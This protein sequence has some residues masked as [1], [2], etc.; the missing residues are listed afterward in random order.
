ME[1]KENQV[2]KVLYTNWRGETAI[3][4]IVPIKVWFGSTNWHKVDGWLLDA[5]DL[6]R[7]AERCYSMKDIKAWWT[8][9]NTEK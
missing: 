7:K 5:Y 3:R 2:I 6:D 9:S 4:S 8:E 1:Y